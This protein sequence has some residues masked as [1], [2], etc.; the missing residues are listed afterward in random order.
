M[1]DLT[2]GIETSGRSGEVVL[3]R[4]S[5]FVAERT[6]QQTGRR[7]A[8]TLIAEVDELLRERGAAPRDC[9]LVAVSIGPGSFTGLRIGVVF[10]KTFAYATGC[11]VAAVDTL[12][13]VAQSS[14]ADIASVYVVSDAQRNQLFVGQYTHSAD[15]IWHPSCEIAIYD[16]KEWSETRSSEDV[17]TGPAA[18]KL[19][20]LGLNCRILPDEFREPKA[21]TVAILGEWQSAA[22]ELS[23][24]WALEPFYLRKSAAEEK[25]DQ[26]HAES[27]TLPK[28]DT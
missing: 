13:C 18:K 3:F 17:I 28:D 27:K 2:L 20:S 22:G 16:I 4:G 25:W 11:A 24:P 9:G 10:A 23:D 26:K 8:Q 19:E 7:H 1:S 15:G 6:L 5:E 14:P 12:R 21:T